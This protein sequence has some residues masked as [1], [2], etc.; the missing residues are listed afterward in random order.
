[1]MPPTTVLVVEDED[2]QRSRLVRLLEALPD[3]EVVG[4]CANGLEAIDAI[5]QLTPQLVLLDVQMP[6]RNGLEVIEAIYERMD[7][8][9]LPV[10][11]FVTAYDRYALKAFELH[12]FDFLLKPFDDERL[13]E[14]LQRARARTMQGQ[15]HDLA[16]QLLALVEH[17][18]LAAGEVPSA[19]PEPPLERVAVRTSDRLTIIKTAEIDWIEGA[20][21]YVQLHVGR[22]K[23]ALRETLS[24]LEERLDGNRFVRIHRS[25][26]VNVDRVRELVSHF[27]GEYLV[28][29][30][31]GTQLK[32]TRSYRDRLEI[33]A[34]RTG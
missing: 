8:A 22:K 11:I 23:Y 10:I 3:F 28:V 20:G 25:T 26:I 1:M 15:M 14:A 4:E 29:L 21:V 19:S 13:E 16:R 17:F 18:G 34:G 12:A 7:P 32:M 27:H 5:L 24:N 31:D 2:R 30:E 33:I 9:R 6:E